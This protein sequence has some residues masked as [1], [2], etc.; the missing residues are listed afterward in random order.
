MGNRLSGTVR[1]GSKHLP[2]IPAT[3]LLGL[4]VIMPLCMLVWFSFS[5][6]DGRP[7]LQNFADLIDNEVYLRVLGRSLVFSLAATL[8]SI[9][10]GWP[11]A[12]ALARYVPARWRPAL[13]A[14]TI[15]PFLTSYLLLI[16]GMYVL[17]SPGGPLSQLLMALGVSPEASSLL[18]SPGATFLMIINESLGFI[19]IIMFVACERIDER[20]I[21]AAQ[22]L[23]GNRWTVFKTVVWP[24]SERSLIIAFVITFVPAAG[25][26]V[27]S[28]I[29]GGPDNVLFGNLINE[30][31]AT[32]GDLNSG[33]M[34][35]LTLLAAIMIVVIGVAALPALFDFA[36]RRPGRRRG[37]PHAIAP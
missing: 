28:Q 11:A 34:L 35:S 26:F 33:A 30:E 29:L 37:A 5:T 23:G 4:L 12:W 9:A 19:V 22:S 17:L 2:M 16:Y 10:V 1:E 3:L 18:Y 13:L 15:V 24:L 21:E 20:L 7:T 36:V 27:E 25:L 14:S 32:F 31:I 6:N 8:V